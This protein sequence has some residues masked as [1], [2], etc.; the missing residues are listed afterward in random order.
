ME[1]KAAGGGGVLLNKIRNE[2]GYN[3]PGAWG[4]K[5]MKHHKGS[6]KGIFMK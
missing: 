4:L 5:L 3:K 2:Q 6:V 1:K